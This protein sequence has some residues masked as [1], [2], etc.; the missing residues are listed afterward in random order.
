M[1]C[2]DP[3]S[4]DTK[5]A[6]GGIKLTFT[7]PLVGAAATTSAVGGG[8]GGVEAIRASI[9]VTAL[10]SQILR[11]RG[12]RSQGVGATSTT[13]Q[14]ELL[15]DPTHSTKSNIPGEISCSLHWASI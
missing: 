2:V 7:E 1:P 15:A 3:R 13:L 12:F 6:N 9:M 8:G 4:L 10:C 11:I 14:A 5:Q